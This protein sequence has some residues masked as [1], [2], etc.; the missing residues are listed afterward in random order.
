MADINKGAIQTTMKRLQGVI[1][2][3]NGQLASKGSGFV[4]YRVNDYDAANQNDL[5]RIIL[6]RYGIRADAK[7]LFFDGTTADG[8]LAKIVDLNRPLTRLDAQIVK[9]EIS[10]NRPDETRDVCVFCN[11]SDPGS[12]P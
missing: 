12:L 2:E 11:G 3:K 1:A 4:H 6:S 7:D 5:K 9:D 10:D 8:R